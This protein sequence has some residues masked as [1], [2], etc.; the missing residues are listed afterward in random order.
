MLKSLAWQILRLFI[1][2][3]L[4]AQIAFDF[5]PA[6]AQETQSSTSMPA[7]ATETV[8]T[9]SAT[10]EAKEK[11]T[12]SS[13]QTP[14]DQ[15]QKQKKAPSSKVSYPQPPN[16]YNMEEIEKFNEELYGN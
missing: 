5:K 6:L 11:T 2:V 3:V 8:K 1:L 13:Q 7:S 9:P 16:P 14:R 4:V 12:P 15:S 10:G